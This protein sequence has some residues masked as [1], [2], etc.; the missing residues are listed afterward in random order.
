MLFVCPQ[1]SRVVCVSLLLAS[2]AQEALHK[3]LDLEKKC[4]KW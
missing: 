4:N 1:L 3:L 2:P